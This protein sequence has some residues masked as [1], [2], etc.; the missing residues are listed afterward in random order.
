MKKIQ[1]SDNYKDKYL[2]NIIKDA[3]DKINKNKEYEAYELSQ[4][5]KNKIDNSLQFILEIINRINE[6]LM[7]AKKGL[8]KNVNILY[9]SSI[10]KNIE[11]TEYQKIV[12]NISSESKAKY[13]FTSIL[14]LHYFGNCNNCRKNYENYTFNTCYFMNIDFPENHKFKYKFSELFEENLL[15]YKERFKKED[16]C[17]GYISKKNRINY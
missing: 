3:V 4:M 6:E 11:Y 7:I 12:K 13:L 9:S 1:I 10:S 5:F 15:V 8:N 2:I 16:I 17:N 14:K